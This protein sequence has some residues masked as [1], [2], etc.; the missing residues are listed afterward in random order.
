MI[1][2]TLISLTCHLGKIT[3]SQF[4]SMENFS[5][6]NENQAKLVIKR[7]TITAVMGHP[8]FMK[9]ATSWGVYA[10]MKI[11]EAVSN[12]SDNELTCTWLRPLI[13]SITFLKYIF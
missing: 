8:N 5:D 2:T 10:Y 11:Q 9:R 13:M 12:T 4:E 1:I 7:Q 6:E 3:C